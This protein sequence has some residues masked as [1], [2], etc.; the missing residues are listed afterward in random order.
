MKCMSVF[1]LVVFWPIVKKKKKK[2]EGAFGCC[3]L[4]GLP[5]RFLQLPLQ[6]FVI[7]SP[8]NSGEGLEKKRE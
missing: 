6:R 3:S 4:R 5:L 2:G 8:G 1:I 7:S